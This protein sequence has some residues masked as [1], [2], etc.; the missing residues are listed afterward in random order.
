MV[1]VAR[2]PAGIA[3][4]KVVRPAGAGIVDSCLAAAVAGMVE[5]YRVVM[6]KAEPCPARFAVGKAASLAVAVA[7]KA[8][9]WPPCP[10][11]AYRRVHQTGPG[12]AYRAP[13]RRAYPASR[14]VAGTSRDHRVYL[15]FPSAYPAAGTASAERRLY[16]LVSLAPGQVIERE[17]AV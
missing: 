2:P 5:A 12:P 17:L 11:P 1:K 4:G 3:G 9:A 15:L 10:A 13:S 7:E 16:S 6:G 8:A 14:L